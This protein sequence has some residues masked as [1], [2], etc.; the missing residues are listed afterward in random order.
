M[1]DQCLAIGFI[2]ADAPRSEKLRQ[3]KRLRRANIIRM[4]YQEIKLDACLKYIK[5]GETLIVCALSDLSGSLP[6]FVEFMNECESKGVGFCAL[7][8][9]DF[10]NA[11][12]Q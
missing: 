10:V 6:E 7:K 11:D 9:G 2:R 3:I 12:L 4:M 5:K 1:N 8:E